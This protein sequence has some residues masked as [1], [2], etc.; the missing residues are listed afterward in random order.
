MK[1]LPEFVPTWSRAMLRP[2]SRLYGSIIGWRNWCYD[3]GWGV[4]RLPVPVISVGNIT[5]GGTG[6]TP[7]VIALAQMLQKQNVRLA[8]ISRG[9]RRKGRGVI[10]VSDGQGNRAPVT[11]SGDELAIIAERL[12]D[13]VVIAARRRYD[14][15]QR[16]CRQFGAQLVVLDDGFQHRQLHRNLDVVMVDAAT[17]DPANALVPAGTLR[18]SPESLHRAHVLCC[19]GVNRSALEHHARCGANVIEGKRRIARWCSLHGEPIEAPQGAVLAVCA[20]AKP[21]GFRQLLH[22]EAGLSVQHVLH[23]RDHHW[24]RSRDVERILA[25]ARSTRLIAVTE[26]DAVK[27]RPYAEQFERAGCVV[28]VAQMS[29]DF[30]PADW[31]L[32]KSIV[33]NLLSTRMP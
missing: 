8:V 25:A 29:L 11:A 12:P 7:M 31:R 4:E 1:V 16:A 26:K 28:A 27:L 24:Y 18:E 21:E 22:D 10:V 19:V 20:I 9:Y 14:G 2:I 15:A 17:L 33:F 6:K 13:A 3:R 5:T 23:W 32:L 30:P